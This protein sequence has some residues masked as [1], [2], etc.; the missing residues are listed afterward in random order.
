MVIADVSMV[1]DYLIYYV[2]DQNA[3][4]NSTINNLTEKAMLFLNL[5][6]KW[7]AFYLSSFQ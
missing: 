6:F 5:S 1:T 4:R 2:C 7:N 3:D